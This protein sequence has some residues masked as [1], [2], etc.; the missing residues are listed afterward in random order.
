[1][2]F[3]GLDGFN[4]HDEVHGFSVF[5]KSYSIQIC[6]KN[7][8]HIVVSEGSGSG[9]SSS[10]DVA[11]I[12]GVVGA[13]LFIIVIIIIL[14]VVMCCVRRSKLRK[15]HPIDSNKTSSNGKCDWICEKGSST[16][17]QYTNFD[18]S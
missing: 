15:M 9:G 14:L 2:G 8:V 1:V 18:D 13:V 6:L 10:G 7:Y 16:H 17:I 5:Y 4:V 12:G 11:I 3:N